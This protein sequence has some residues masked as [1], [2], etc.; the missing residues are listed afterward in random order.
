MRNR[1]LIYAPNVHQGGGRTLL[2][3]LLRV[4]KAIDS[5]E[6]ILFLDSRMTLPENAS[7]NLHIKT[8]ASSML[9]RICAEW[10][11]K[12]HVGSQDTVLC[13]GNLPPLFKLRGRVN[14]FLQNRYL[15]DK[16]ALSD[17][18]FKAR[19]HITIGRLWLYWRSGNA[20]KFVVQSLSMKTVLLSSGRAENKR[21]LIRPF[22]SL[23]GLHKRTMSP[24]NVAQENR[25][26]YDFIY[27]AS[28]EPHKNHRRLIEAWCVLAEQKI[29]PSLC[30]TLDE[31]IS[32]ELC[33]W[34]NEQK[35]SYG[36]KITNVGF[37]PHEEVMLNYAQVRALIYPSLFESL[38]LPLIEANQSA[39]PVLASERDYVRDVIEPEQTFDPE[40]ITSIAR[41]VQRFIGKNE[42]P[43]PLLNAEQFIRC[44]LDRE[45]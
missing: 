19:L 23:S 6:V 24:Q 43:L 25:K 7:Q 40:S 35:I 10:W 45:E 28:G 14:V 17:F 34:I 38:G 12:R 2:T 39:L 31:N 44:I 22:S 13:F 5:Y 41:A 20:D 4:V 26:Q 1:F 16:V 36:L 32:T 29:F 9:H 37:L 3:E 30:L 33:A 21:I 15:V 11:L 8:V 27:P 42:Q 18:N